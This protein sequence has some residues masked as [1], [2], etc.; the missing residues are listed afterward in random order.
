MKFDN[1]GICNQ[2]DWI[3]SDNNRKPQNCYRHNFSNQYGR[4]KINNKSV[5]IL[6]VN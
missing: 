5:V 2:C 1:D 3:K 6:L 4:T